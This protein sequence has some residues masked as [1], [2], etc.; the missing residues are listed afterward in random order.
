MRILTGPC[1]PSDMGYNT[2]LTPTYSHILA[3]SFCSPAAE[4]QNINLKTALDEHQ[5][6]KPGFL[7]MLL[8]YASDLYYKH[9]ERFLSDAGV[10]D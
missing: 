5:Y 2:D 3:V 8:I 1:A 7:Q 6:V 9:L 4:V 10:L